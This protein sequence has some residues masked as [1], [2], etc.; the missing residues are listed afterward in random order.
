[1]SIEQ[2]KLCL[3]RKSKSKLVSVSEPKLHIRKKKQR[4]NRLCFSSI[5]FMYSCVIS[6]MHFL[7][8]NGKGENYHYTIHLRLTFAYIVVIARIVCAEIRRSIYGKVDASVLHLWYGCITVWH[9]SSFSWFIVSLF[10]KY[11][12]RMHIATDS[13]VL[14]YQF[15]RRQCAEAATSSPETMNAR[16]EYIYFAFSFQ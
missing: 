15:A 5:V 10:T 3:I 13:S 9:K 1:M 7:L 6:S 12:Q 8:S 2:L 16:N 4:R 14:T 11:A